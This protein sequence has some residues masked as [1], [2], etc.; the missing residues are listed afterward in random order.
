M[1]APSDTRDQNGYSYNYIIEA[2]K[3]NVFSSTVLARTKHFAGRSGDA[4]VQYHT[5]SSYNRHHPY[6]DDDYH[7]PDDHRHRNHAAPVLRSPPALSRLVS[8]LYLTSL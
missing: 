8:F 2:Q 5:K 7:H 6:P 1:N 3:R 4:I